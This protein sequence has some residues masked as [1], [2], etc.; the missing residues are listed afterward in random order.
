[1]GDAITLLVLRHTPDPVETLPSQPADH[2]AAMRVSIRVPGSTSNL[3]HGFDCMGIAVDLTNTLTVDAREDEQVTCPTAPD[4]GLVDMADRVRRTCAAAWGCRLPGFDV[5]ITGAVPISRGLGSSS[6]I[7]LGL[8]AACQLFAGHVLDRDELIRIGVGLEGHPDNITASALGGFTLAGHDRHGLVWQ[9]FPVPAELCCVVAIP[10]HEVRTADARR[11]LPGE[12]NLGA[13]IIGWQR[14]ALIT[15]A[16]ASG[17]I[18]RLRGLLAD[19]WHERYREPL[20][21]GFTIARDAA[22]RAGALGTIISG[23]GSTVLSFC[24]PTEQP[25]VAEALRQCYP[26]NS[27]RILPLAFDNDGLTQISTD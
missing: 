15:G 20:N 7:F 3:G 1:M 5:R 18:Q 6:T 8:G 11:A 9:R 13:A 24:S 17:E 26:E 21:P 25:T 10:D 4:G 2:Y 14:S 23:S 22:E 12:L 27:S 19:G 16:L